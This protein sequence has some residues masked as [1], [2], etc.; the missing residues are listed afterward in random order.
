VEDLT[1][2][3][4]SE[5]EPNQAF[6]KIWRLRNE[7]TCTWTQQYTLTFIGGQSMGAA[8]EINLTEAVLPGNTIDL[9]IDLQAPVGPGAYQGFWKLRADDNTTFGIGPSGD[10]SFWVK[11]VVLDS[12]VANPSPAV[13]ATAIPSVT[14]FSAATASPGPTP[15]PTT[16]PEIESQGEMML[17][18]GSSFDLDAGELNPDSGFDL[19]W[20][21]S[22]PDVQA[23]IPES[24]S[25]LQ[26]LPPESGR[27]DH[28]RCR[29]EGLVSI[30]YQASQLSPGWFLC[31]QTDEG[32]FGWLEI[33]AF[34]E[35]FTFR[36]QTW[37]SE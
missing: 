14:T 24:G 16:T 30:P 34:D 4:R 25:Q 10:Q 21:E 17:E 20:G 1:V 12:M 33:I 9:S 18:Q 13:S 27:P 11:I 36:F 28:A 2:R 22:T 35:S 19:L 3:D 31:Y 15:S 32:R 26:L 6:V 29:T 23:L 37:R 7:G 8:T 5:F